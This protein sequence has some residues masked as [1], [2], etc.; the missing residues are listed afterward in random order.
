ML[1]DKRLHNADLAK[2]HLGDENSRDTGKRDAKKFLFLRISD[3]NKKG[4]LTL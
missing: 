4:H 1:K 2:L 3:F